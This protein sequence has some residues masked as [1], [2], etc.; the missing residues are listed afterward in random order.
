[1]SGCVR[2]IALA[3]A[4]LVAMAMVH[5]AVA[6]P[7]TSI[8]YRVT[9]HPEGL[10]PLAIN[11]EEMGQGPVL[12]L[13][14]GLGGSS[15]T[16]RL[17]APKLAAAHRVIAIDLRGFGR[18]DKPFDLAYSP[19][20]HAAVVRA[21]ITEQKL[22]PLTLVGHSFGGLLAMLLAQDRRLAPNRISRLVLM[23]APL[24]P[25]PFSPGVAFLRQPLLPYLAL[26]L[27]PGEL[28]T[29][30]ALM[31]EKFG[32]ER[33][34]SR[35]ISIYADPLGDPGGPHALIETAVQIVPRDLDRIIA[36]YPAVTKPTLLIWCRE[37]QVVPLASGRRLA[38]TLPQARLA[39]IDGCDHV[40]P[41]QA[42]AA[43]V[44]EM[45]RFL[46]RT[47]ANAAP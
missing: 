14:H 13:L 33:L 47:A 1:M 31:M 16:W 19:A 42:P 20:H 25:Q 8:G 35:D 46:D 45:T 30:I 36:R 39:V 10:P 28:P 38:R 21:F 11:V 17:V 27:V 24:Y 3:V 6:G 7:K 5:A 2:V 37:D 4:L 34:T 15:Y 26:T 9:V 43:V 40:P 12:L 32:F 22:P 23:D 44:L 29:T 18:S 41:E